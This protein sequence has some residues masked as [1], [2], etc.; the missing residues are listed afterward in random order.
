MT[1]GPGQIVSEKK[2]ET[3][4]SHLDIHKGNSN[5]K[6]I[7][8]ATKF[9]ESIAEEASSNSTVIDLFSIVH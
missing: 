3:L 2:S 8:K 9:F 6:Y 7:T 4:R 5:T 1:T